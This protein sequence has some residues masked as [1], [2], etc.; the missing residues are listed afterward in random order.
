MK[1]D[2]DVKG[3]DGVIERM[4]G[5]SGKEQRKSYRFAMRKAMAPVKAAAQQ[6]ASRLDD[7]KTARDI[8]KNI[9][10]ATGRR[11]PNNQEMMRVGVLGGARNYVSNKSNVRK[12]RAGAEYSVGG[13]K[14]NPGGNT[15]YWRFLEL[16]TRFVHQQEF[17]RPA[18]HSQAQAVTDTLAKHLSLAIDRA[19]KRAAK[20][21]A[22]Q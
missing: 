9:A 18:L 12:G 16:G 3:L 8:A 13:D 22:A 15:W 21:A 20:K 5:L 11:Q 6:G 17:L 2:V 4:R 14:S 7:P 19:V 10:I 1:F